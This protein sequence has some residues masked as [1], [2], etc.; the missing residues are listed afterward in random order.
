MSSSNLL[1]DD[2]IQYGDD[3]KYI[4]SFTELKNLLKMR[5]G[6]YNSND[7]YLI[8]SDEA[9]TN[10]KVGASLYC[11]NL[12]TVDEKC[13][14]STKKNSMCVEDKST[15]YSTK[16]KRCKVNPKFITNYQVQDNVF[17]NIVS[18][19]TQNKTCGGQKKY[20]ITTCPVAD[21]PCYM[22]QGGNNR[23]YPLIKNR[24]AKNQ[25]QYIQVRTKPVTTRSTA[26]SQKLKSTSTSS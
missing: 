20:D 24:D 16:R 21:Y 3:V 15:S 11:E 10:L 13:G 4:T 26:Q 1:V 5:N 6:E 25:M 22:N 23:C 14:T 9:Y 19:H 18:G 8:L 2:D 17:Q 12:V 7:N